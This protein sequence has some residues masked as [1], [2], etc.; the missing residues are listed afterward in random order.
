M[1]TGIPLSAHR[2]DIWEAFS[3][4]GANMVDVRLVQPKGGGRPL[5]FAFI[6]F[7]SIEEATSW[8]EGTRQ[9]PKIANHKLYLSYCVTT[10][11]AGDGLEAHPTHVLIV[12]GLSLE[13][14]NKS[15]FDAFAPFAD[16]KE[17]RLIREYETGAS[18]GFA[19][20]EFAA[21]ADPGLLKV[22]K[23]AVP[24]VKVDGVSVT[25]EYSRGG[26]NRDAA[27]PQ[28]NSKVASAAIEAAMAMSAASSQSSIAIAKKPAA[29]T[30]AVAPA[31]TA[32]A[33]AADS[34]PTVP[35]GLA[36]DPTTQF[37]YD[38]KTLYYWDA[39]TGYYYDGTSGTYLTLD[40]Q[41]QAYTP[42]T[43]S[44]QA[45]AK[46]TH[47]A[48]AKSKAKKAQ[49]LNAKKAL[50]DMQRW[51]KMSKKRKR[52]TKTAEPAKQ[53]TG[54]IAA[55]AGAGAGAAGPAAAT[56]GVSVFHQEDDAP[57]PAAAAAFATQPLP[58]EA[59]LLA[60]FS[61]PDIDPWEASQ[62][63]QHA[64]IDRLACLLCQRR[65][66]T[67]E[68][69]EKHVRE[70]ALHLKNLE[71]AS[72]RIL[73][74]LSP[75]QMDEYERVQRAAGYRD[76]AAERRGVHGQPGKIKQKRPSKQAP[77]PKPEQPTKHGIGD[78]NIGAKMLKGMGWNKGQGLGKDGQG[79]TAP[80]KAEM[81]LR[82]AGIGAA[83][84]FSAE[85]RGPDEGYAANAA[86]SARHR[87]ATM[88]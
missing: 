43:A 19:F 79:I 88:S 78:D 3:S 58:E 15:V 76:R 50:E 30:A 36:Y 42:V 87:F 5:D 62:Q 71:A 72:T 2:N 23:T 74:S 8:V 48:N 39:T 29:A 52:K 28:K 83:P 31:A 38:P 82:G 65:M 59:S 56:P 49:T 45:K 25:V 86:A 70:S 34:T 33:A 57:P 6:E 18:K 26:E 64:Q 22:I 84:T 21:D 54:A 27:P 61:Q 55:G 13:S 77:A 46:A 35:A 12:K 24:T 51:E 4:L 75:E 40:P 10:A 41:S 67:V 81:R 60:K 16:L 17:V 44:L 37:Y 53:A 32:S 73:A 47:E 80:I 63:R 1:I 69:L 7:V 11:A 9:L 68:K 20:L 85:D 66:P 14:T